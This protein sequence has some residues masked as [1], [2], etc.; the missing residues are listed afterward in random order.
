LDLNVFKHFDFVYTHKLSTKIFYKYSVPNQLLHPKSFHPPYTFNSIIK[1][2][3]LR[4]A[5]RCSF[6]EDFDQAV[7]MLFS[8]LSKQGF[9]YRSLRLIKSNTLKCLGIFDTN[10]WMFGFYN[11]STCLQCSYGFPSPYVFDSV[12]SLFRIQSYINCSSHN[13]IYI[14]FCLKCG[15]LYINFSSMPLNKTISNHIK[16]INFKPESFLSMHFNTPNHSMNL[17]K[18]QG[19]Q[20]CNSSSFPITYIQKWFNRLRFYDIEYIP[21]LYYPSSNILSLPFSRRNHYLAR[22]IKNKI[23][24]KYNISINTTYLGHNNIKSMLCPSKLPS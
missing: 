6:K 16:E 4:I 1:S 24:T 21:P 17:F 19:I 20:V 5:R 7:S 18:Y 8:V 9:S 3:I 23:S 11:C 10:S 13:C 12:K 22:Q 14:L 15:P 2:Q